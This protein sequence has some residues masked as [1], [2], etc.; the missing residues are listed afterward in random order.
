MPGIAKLEESVP[1]KAWQTQG[2]HYIPH[3]QDGIDMRRTVP[4][5]CSRNRKG[6]RQMGN[7][8]T[9]YRMARES[10]LATS[11]SKMS[12]YCHGAYFAV[13]HI[14]ATQMYD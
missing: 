13:I 11:Q 10:G 4:D 3:A 2:G 1:Q 7:P 12:T 6:D 5:R 14:W 9:I 8:Q